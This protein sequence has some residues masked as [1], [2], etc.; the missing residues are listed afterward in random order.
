M[1]S[2]GSSTSHPHSSSASHEL[3]VHEWVVRP[4]RRIG[5][6]IRYR[7]RCRCGWYGAWYGNRTNA[8]QQ[9]RRHSAGL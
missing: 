7:A 2:A 4:I 9:G 6:P 5:G 3:V 1:H 8:Q